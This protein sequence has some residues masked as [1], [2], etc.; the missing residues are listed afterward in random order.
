MKNIFYLCT[1]AKNYITILLYLRLEEWR[2]SQ[3][4]RQGIANP[5]SP[6]QIWVPPNLF[7]HFIIV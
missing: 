1:I 6:V 7:I 4:V 5:L 3:V 2:Y